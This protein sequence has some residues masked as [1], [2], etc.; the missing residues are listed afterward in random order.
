MQ[1]RLHLKRGQKGTKQLLAR[2]ETVSCVCASA[3][4]TVE[5][6]NGFAEW[7]QQHA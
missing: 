2:Y 7:V 1:T 6:R 4:M 3:T 5:E